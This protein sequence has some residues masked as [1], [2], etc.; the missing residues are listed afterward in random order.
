MTRIKPILWSIALAGAALP[1]LAA[2]S[3][4][5][6]ISTSDVAATISASGMAVAPE[7]ITFLTEVVATRPAPALKVRSVER[8]GSER[9]S[10]RME[11]I[12]SDQCLPFFVAIRTDGQ[13]TK[14]SAAISAMISRRRNCPASS[15]R[16]SSRSHRKFVSGWPARP[17][18]YPGQ[19]P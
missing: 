16:C 1:A 2:T 15:S 10:A 7:Q 12:E 3:E 11:C 4:H 5:Y 18:S 17:H 6:P 9:L 13:N 19:V 8:I 14:Q